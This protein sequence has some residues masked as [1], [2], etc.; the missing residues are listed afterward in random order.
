MPTNALFVEECFFSN[1]MKTKRLSSQSF[2]VTYFVNL[3]PPKLT[4]CYSNEIID[5]LVTYSIPS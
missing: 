1:M 3:T 4:T 2:F 5:R